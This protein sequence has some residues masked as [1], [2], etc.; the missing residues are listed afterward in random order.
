MLSKCV[1]DFYYSNYVNIVK[2][3]VINC[4]MWVK[5]ERVQGPKFLLRGFCTTPLYRILTEWQ[6]NTM[7]IVMLQKLKWQWYRP[8]LWSQWCQHF[9]HDSNGA[10]TYY[11]RN[12]ANILF[13]TAVVPHFYL[14]W[15]WCQPLPMLTNGTTPLWL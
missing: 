2:F 12:G 6:R 7:M 13:M 9:I 11:D 15:K 4:T 3:K 1:T 14:W 5:D 8:L 10:I